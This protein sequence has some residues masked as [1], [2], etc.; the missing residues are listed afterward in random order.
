LRIAPGERVGLLGPSGSG[1]STL[2]SLLQRAYE[3]H[4]GRIL[5]GGHDIADLDRDRLG[6]LFASVPQDAWLLHRSTLENVR[7]GR[8][9]AT[10]EDVAAVVRAARCEDFIDGLPAGLATVVGHRG[11]KLSGGQRQ[12]IAIARALLKDAPV[13]LLDEAT[14]A[15]DPE[16]EEA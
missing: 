4:R 3:P 10:A 11:L 5:V 8:P 9:E 2:L 13:V 6:A 15:L 7:Y 14:S 12:R 1:K 16:S